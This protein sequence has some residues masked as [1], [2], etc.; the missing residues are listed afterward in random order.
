MKKLFILSMVLIFTGCAHYNPR[1]ARALVYYNSQINAYLATDWL[2][3]YDHMPEMT[4][5]QIASKT[6]Q[7]NRLLSEFIWSVDRNYDRFEIQFYSNQAA[8]DVASDFISMGLAGGAVLTGNGHTKTILA[9]IASFATGAH[10]SIDARWYNSQTR[11][12]IVSEMRALRATQLAL[13]EQSMEAT[14]SAYTLDQGIL[15]V[16]AYYAA[17]S[18]VSGLQAISETASSHADAAQKA[19]QQMRRPCPKLSPCQ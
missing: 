12:A 13:I 17:G 10:A 19:L 8:T 5:Q 3:A 11:E 16:Q 14:L 6:E 1:A 15:D 18:V 9:M 4:P 2:T 7:R